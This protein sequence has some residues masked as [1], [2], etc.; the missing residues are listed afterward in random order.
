MG[1]YRSPPTHSTLADY[2][3]G[4]KRDVPLSQGALSALT[5]L[6]IGTSGKVFK[7]K[8]DGLKSAWRVLVKRLCIENL[9]FHDLRHEAV[10]RLFELGTL[11]YL[12][13]ATISGHK[14]VQMLKRYTIFARKRSCQSLT[15]RRS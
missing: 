9:H 1:K 13:I 7:Y 12:E 4:E 6:G 2:Q 11:D 14:S 3:N 5:R 10:S 8:P 15:E